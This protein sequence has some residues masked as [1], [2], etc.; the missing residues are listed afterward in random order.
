MGRIDEIVGLHTGQKV[1]IIESIMGRIDSVGERFY[2]KAASS[3]ISELD[4][5]ITVDEIYG[6]MNEKHKRELK[7][8]FDF[9]LS[10]RNHSGLQELNQMM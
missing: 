3:V 1:N 5:G 4:K 7:V 10:K 9:Y 6:S 2:M 8:A